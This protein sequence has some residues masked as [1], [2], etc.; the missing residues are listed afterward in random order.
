MWIFGLLN[1][2]KAHFQQIYCPDRKGENN[3]SRVHSA[4]S[5]H[6]H[7]FKSVAAVLVGCGYNDIHPDAHRHGI[8]SHQKEQAIV[9]LHTE[10]KAGPRR[11]YRRQ[12]H[13][14]SVHWHGS[15]WFYCNIETLKHKYLLDQNFTTDCNQA[16]AMS[17]NEAGKSCLSASL[18]AWQTSFLRNLKGWKSVDLKQTNINWLFWCRAEYDLKFTLSL[19]MK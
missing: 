13:Q 9:C 2:P 5:L 11:L 19:K 12:R 6:S 1:P 17:N 18:E 15:P 3:H 10:R 8:G 14:E 4:A 7:V 16:S